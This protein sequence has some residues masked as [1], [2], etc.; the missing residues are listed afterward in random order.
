MN[1]N[2]DRCI[3]SINGKCMDEGK[4][5]DCPLTKIKQEICEKNDEIKKACVDLLVAYQ[6]IGELTE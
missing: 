1:C 4:Y 2:F 6:I 5:N 3:F